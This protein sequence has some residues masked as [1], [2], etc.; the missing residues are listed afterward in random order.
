MTL[1]QDNTAAD[2]FYQAAG[3][4]GL[5][6]FGL[7]LWA[8]GLSSV[9]GASFTSLSFLT[10]QGFD[11]KKRS[12]LTVGFILISTVIYLFLGAAPQALLIFA[13][14]FNGLILP[15]G[16]GIVLWAGWRRKD[17]LRGYNHPTWLLV[18]GAAVLVLTICMGASSLTELAAL[19]A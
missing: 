14:A 10:K 8:A 2:A 15:L 7:V 1:S 3:E 9:I 11:E 6:A 19:W 17:L 13:G 12:W 5:R 18:L 4:F 16:F